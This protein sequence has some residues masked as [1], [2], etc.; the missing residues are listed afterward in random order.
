MKNIC[1]CLFL[2]VKVLIGLLLLYKFLKIKEKGWNSFLIFILRFGFV[3][4]LRNN[5][6]FKLYFIIGKNI[7]F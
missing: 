7:I 1:N 3:F 5:K 4:N 6:K 2:F